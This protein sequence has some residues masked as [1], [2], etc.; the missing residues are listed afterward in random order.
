[1]LTLSL[2]LSAILLA[3]VNMTAR[4]SAQPVATIVVEA[5]F[6][7]ICPVLLMLFLPALLLQALLLAWAA[8]AWCLLGRRPRTFLLLSST[9]TLAAYAIVGG[10][11]YLNYSRLREQFAYVSMD[12]RLPPRKNARASGSLPTA[13]AGRLT[14]LEGIIE[15]QEPIGGMQ[16]IRLRALEQLHEDA[17]NAFINESGFGVS[18]MVG[19]SEWALK[20][21]LREEPPLPQPAARGTDRWSAS[22]L[23]ERPDSKEAEPDPGLLHMHLLGVAD[24]VNRSGFGF[25]KDRRHVAG[26]Q[27]HQFS[28]L[29]EPGAAWRLKTLELVGLVVHEEPV[30]YVSANLPRMDDLR[31][32]PTRPLDAFEAAGLAALNRGHDLFA[33]DTADGHRRLLGAVRSGKHCLSCHGGQRGELLGAFSYT[34]ARGRP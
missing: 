21:G 16:D 30:A 20:Q 11:A 29:P 9:T 25:F 34:L 31:K 19:M 4:R 10:T 26:F 3:I 12:D 2:I 23:L 24:F 7:A 6:F 17:V 32:T 33:R 18:R 5:A 1:M 14:R 8:V 15:A 27:A 22:T 28:R 13:T